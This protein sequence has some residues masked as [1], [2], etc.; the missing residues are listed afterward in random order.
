[1]QETQK[2]WVE[3]LGGEASLEKKKATHCSTLAWRIPWTEEPG[4]LQSKELQRVAKSPTQVS[5]CV[6]SGRIKWN[7]VS[8]VL[9]L[10]L[11][12]ESRQGLFSA[13]RSQT[14]CGEETL[15]D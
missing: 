15:V 7:L 5:T 4:G 13:R 8:P 10:Q 9:T 6:D 14:H 3:P 11:H 12:R 1:M 2:T